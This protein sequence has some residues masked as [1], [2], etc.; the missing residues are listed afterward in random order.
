M[1]EKEIEE[2][3]NER[4]LFLCKCCMTWH[5]F[6]CLCWLTSDGKRCVKCCQLWDI[7]HIM[8]VITMSLPF[9]VSLPTNGDDCI[10]I[11]WREVYTSVNMW[12]HFGETEKQPKNNIF[13]FSPRAFEITDQCSC[14][15][16]S[17][18]EGKMNSESSLKWH[19]FTQWF[20]QW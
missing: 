16:L 12:E 6:K 19:L 5:L 9:P 10:C 4:E 7:Q 8:W 1:V 2:K 17:N 14:V 3:K 13:D 18:E 20:S 15:Q 11:T